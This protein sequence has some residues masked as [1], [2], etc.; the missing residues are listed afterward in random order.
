MAA[1]LVGMSF[2]VTPGEAAYLPLTHAYADAPAQLPLDEVLAALGPGWNPPSIAKVGQNLSTTLMCLP[3]HGIPPGRYCRRHD[4]ML[5]IYG[6][7][8]GPAVTHM[9]SLA[10]RHLGLKTLSYTETFAAK[11]RSRSRSREVA[12][13]V[14]SRYAAG[15]RHHPAAAPQ[16]IEAARTRSRG[17]PRSIAR[18]SCRCSGAL[19]DGAPPGC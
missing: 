8:V 10:S 12:V 11:G 5:P 17:L 14:P 3:T 4:T 19:R 2:S 7:G 13:G 9:D 15:C 1:K 16:A 6:S 18:S